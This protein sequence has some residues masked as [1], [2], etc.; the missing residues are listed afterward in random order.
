V[1]NGT[2]RIR[3]LQSVRGPS[4]TTNPYI[5]Q[6][7]DA[8]RQDTDVEYFTW[9]RGIL[10]RHDLVHLHWPEVMTRRAG[11]AARIAARVRFALFLMRLAASRTPVVRTLHNVRSHESGDRVERLLMRWCDRLTTGWILLNPDTPVPGPAPTRVIPHGHYRDVY[12]EVDDAPVPDR[13]LHFGIIRPYKGIDTL[14]EAAGRLPGS[15]WSL[16]VVGSPTTDRLRHLV[17]QACAHD[18]RISAHLA[19]VDEVE[20]SRELARAQLVVLPYRELHN[21]GAALLALSLNRAVLVPRG[22]TTVSLAEEVGPDWV[23]FYDDDL[24]AEDLSRALE[25][26]R[27]GPA[28]PGEQGV[29]DLSARRWRTIAERHQEFFRELLDP[30]SR[31]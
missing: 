19:Y 6:L 30:G 2:R 21:S 24:D 16:R 26:T 20:L 5:T 28:A 1:G 31:H 13:L 9:H 7:V 3:V 27:T 14:L 17:E 10:G 22:S 12:P 11:R 8:L 4:P 15:Q 18:S 25:A 23:L 29:P